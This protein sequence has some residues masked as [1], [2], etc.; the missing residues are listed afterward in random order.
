MQVFS[1]VSKKRHEASWFAH[2]TYD[3]D[4]PVRRLSTDKYSV[5]SP[6]WDICITHFK[7]Q[8]TSWKKENVIT[9][10]SGGGTVVAW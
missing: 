10:G 7:A 3:W 5:P 1:E 6:K 2:L 8:G 4:K 9:R